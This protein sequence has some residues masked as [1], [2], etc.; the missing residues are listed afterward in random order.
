M[1][2]KQVFNC[3]QK[4]NLLGKDDI[5]VIGVSGGPD[6][7]CLV[8]VLNSIKEK[9]GFE[10]VIAH[11]N[12]LIRENAKKDE[13]F[14]KRYAKKK[15]IAFFSKRINVE[16]LSKIKKIGIEEAGRCARYE[17]FNEVLKEVSGTK[18]AT[19]H[20]K[21][22]NAET[23]LMNI[24]R[25]TGSTGLKG[26][27]AKRDNIYIK[28]LIETSREEIEMYCKENRLRPRY[29]ETNKDNSYTRNKIRNVLIPFLKIGFNP[30]IVETLDRLSKI[31]TDENNYLEGI[32]E[33]TYREILIKEEKE[34]IILNLREFNKKHDLIK[35]RII[36]WCI[37]KLLGNINRNRANSY[38]WYNRDVF[39]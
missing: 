24:L 14:V 30:N 1:V 5:V 6:S 37:K 28:P 39:K 3:I 33:I 36:F 26:I 13:D 20:T 23:V 11:M 35:S 29:D 38:K 34:E 32:T 9:L 15:G 10:I 27:E 7:L 18:I 8:N 4:F 19:A 25:G 12:H 21:N 16:E 22:D 17:F 2:E 31:M